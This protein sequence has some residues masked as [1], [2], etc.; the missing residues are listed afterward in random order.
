LLRAGYAVERGF[1]EE[2]EDAFAYGEAGRALILRAAPDSL[3]TRIAPALA[4]P[5]GVI[6]RKQALVAAGEVQL[7]ALSRRLR[8]VE[9]A[10]RARPTA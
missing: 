8:C 9:I 4:A 1:C 6:A 7:R 5:V 2:I 3:A 10:T